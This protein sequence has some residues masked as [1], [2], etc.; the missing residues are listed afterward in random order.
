M[1]LFLGLQIIFA[2]FFL[3]MLGI[4]H[5]TFIGDYGLK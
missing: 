3:G 2:A 5:E 4:S 1:W